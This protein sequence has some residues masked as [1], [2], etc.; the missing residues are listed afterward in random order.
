MDLINALEKRRTIRKYTQQ[1]IPLEVLEE[2]IRVTRLSPSASNRQP[3]EYLLITD[4][5]KIEKVFETVKWAGYITPKGNPQEGEK[6]TAYAVI[7]IREDLKT[8]FTT[9]DVGAAAQ[10]MMLAALNEGIASCWLGS[11]DREKLR[12]NF[13]IPMKYVI[14]TVIAMGYPAE[15]SEVF[16]MDDSV[17]YFKEGNKYHVP[18]RKTEDILHINKLK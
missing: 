12:S 2:I 11:V 18:K 7:L 1:K 15:E 4:D 8:T 14:D 10:S 6:P 9:H 5:E 3:L 16:D 13:N 17:K